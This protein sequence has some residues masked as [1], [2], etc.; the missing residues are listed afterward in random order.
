LWAFHEN[1]IA[2]RF[3]YEWHDDSG[4]WFRAH[5]NEQWEF[6]ANGLMRR[7]QASIN[8]VPI[9]VSDRKFHWPSGPRPA[10]HGGLTEPGLWA[11]PDLSAPWL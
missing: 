6:D 1:R 2:V 7:R 3:Q 9:L 10:D 11:C 8:N 4:N 5:G